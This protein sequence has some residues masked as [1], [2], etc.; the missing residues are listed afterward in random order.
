MHCT[1]YIIIRLNP[2]A[3]AGPVLAFVQF[4]AALALVRPWTA[5]KTDAPALLC[6]SCAAIVA[7][8]VLVFYALAWKGDGLLDR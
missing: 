3:S 7:L 4:A 6:G 5:A 1:A 2:L 8:F